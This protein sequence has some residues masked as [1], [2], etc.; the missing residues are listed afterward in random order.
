MSLP[1]EAY[2]TTA[3]S[4][5]N[6]DLTGDAREAVAGNL[7]NLRRLAGTFADLPLADDLDPAPVY[8]P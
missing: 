6:L 8:R 1:L 3:A 2:V 7:A 5:L 4:L